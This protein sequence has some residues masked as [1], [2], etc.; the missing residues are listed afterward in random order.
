MALHERPDAYPDFAFTAPADNQGNFT[1][2]QF[3]PQSI[4]IG[5]TFTLTA[6][7]QSS[8]FSAQTA[9]TDAPERRLPS[10]LK[11]EDDVWNRGYR[12]LHCYAGE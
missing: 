12:Y 1:F 7:G 4:D 9:F 8:G 11:R 3:A 5:R 2:M 10:V 6:I